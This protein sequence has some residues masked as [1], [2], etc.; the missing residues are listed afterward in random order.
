[1][2]T[3]P[4][5]LVAT[6]LLL[7]AGCGDGSPEG[8]AASALEGEAAGRAS[9]GD[10]RAIE[11]APELGIDIAQMARLPSGLLVRDDLEGDGAEAA[12]G[13][14]VTVHY[15]GY[16]PDGNVF[17]SSR[18]AGQPLTITLG[19]RQVIEGWEQGIPGMK[20]GGRRVLVIPPHLG[21]GAQGAGGGVIPPNAV[22]VFQVE[23]LAV[24]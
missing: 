14:A 8:D 11:Y 7:A 12:A 19:Q 16:H 23:L 2:R 20:V 6:H 4:A 24:N 10:P 17:D 1:M 15:T 18:N 3:L 13:R 21:Y 22:L 9:T 5:V